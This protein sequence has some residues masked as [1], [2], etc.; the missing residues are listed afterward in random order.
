MDRVCCRHLCRQY[1]S[2]A[3]PAEAR[4]ESYTGPFFDQ[5]EERA[6]EAYSYTA[7]RAATNFTSSARLKRTV[8]GR[9]TGKGNSKH[10]INPASTDA[11]PV[12]SRLGLVLSAQTY[13]V[14]VW[15]PAPLACLMTHATQWSSDD[16]ARR[17]CPRPTRLP[18]TT[19]TKQTESAASCRSGTCRQTFRYSSCASRWRACRSPSS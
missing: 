1:A 12:S 13:V 6:R 15:P 11:S 3:V 14:H 16:S 17:C 9:R 10:N 5:A 19:I 7:P 18:C 2:Y 8:L 4:R